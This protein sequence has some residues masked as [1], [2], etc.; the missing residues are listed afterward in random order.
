MLSETMQAPIEVAG[1][2]VLPEWIDY[3]GHMNVAFY[4]LAFD[5]ALDQ[6]FDVLGIGAEYVRRASHS[7]FILEAHVT[8]VR[9]VVLDDPLRFEF[10]LLDADDKRLHYIVS[11]FHASEGFLAA[12]SEQ[13]CMHIDMAARRSTPLP[14]AIRHRLQSVLA[15][16]ASLPRPPEVGHVIG[17]RRKAGA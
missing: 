13:I 9:E 4:V 8:Y 17:I 11:M 12:R 3:N 5:R 2:R 15:A 6:V 10:Q 1:Q 16:H 14:E 7:F